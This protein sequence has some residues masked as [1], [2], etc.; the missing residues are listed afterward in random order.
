[1][2]YRG[3]ETE[4]DGD[5]FFYYD[6]KE[7]QKGLPNTLADR[8]INRYRYKGLWGFVKAN[9]RLGLILAD[10]SVL[11]LIGFLLVPFLNRQIEDEQW[12]HLKFSAHAYS[13]SDNMLLSLE[14]KQ[15]DPIEESSPLKMEVIVD[16]VLQEQQY[17][18]LPGTRQEDV[19]RLKIPKGKNIEINLIWN[20]ITKTI[21]PDIR[22]GE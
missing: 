15:K 17:F 7:R 8:I 19:I 9:K 11:F 1:M 13:L 12:K 6:R 22:L 4:G 21:K 14:I 20:D 3:P 18:N 5:F 2:I 16:H 10:I